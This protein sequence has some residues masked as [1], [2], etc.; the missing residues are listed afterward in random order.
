MNEREKYDIALHRQRRDHDPARNT[1]LRIHRP[2][3]RP[4]FDAMLTAI[5][6]RLRAPGPIRF[7]DGKSRF[8]A[9]LSDPGMTRE[10]L[11]RAARWALLARNNAVTQQRQEALLGQWTDSF[12][13]QGNS[14]FRTAIVV[15]AITSC[16]GRSIALRS[17]VSR[18]AMRS[19]IPARVVYGP[20]GDD[21]VLTEDELAEIILNITGSEDFDLRFSLVGNSPLDNVGLPYAEVAL[22]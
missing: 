14:L 16:D 22:E 12:V 3:D 11:A 21:L 19:I 17:L 6:H 15:M 13:G 1:P 7:L 8:V 4:V 18:H 9:H 5:E 20:S 2:S 10:I